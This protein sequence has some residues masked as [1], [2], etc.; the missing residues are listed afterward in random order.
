[1]SGSHGPA[2]PAT[3]ATRS[4]S[5]ASRGAPSTTRSW[6]PAEPTDLMPCGLDA[7][8]VT[9]I[10][11]GFIMNGVDYYSA[12]H[13]LIEERKST[14]PTSSAS[15]G[16]CSSIASRSSGRLHSAR[17]STEGAKR[18]F[19][20]LDIDW[21]G[22]GSG[23]STSSVCRPDLPGQRLARRSTGLRRERTLDRTG[24]Q[25]RLVADAEE[26]PGVGTGHGAVRQVGTRFNSRSRSSTVARCR[27]TV[28]TTPFFNPPRKRS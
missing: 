13:C 3:S 24:N 9:R 16:P 18:V 2:T 20:G 12:N 14:R 21:D 15:T 6:Q 4:G 27:R 5:T 7:L 23:C 22:G 11:A 17:R 19:V 26:E 28:V 10:E 25:R 8:D 1:M